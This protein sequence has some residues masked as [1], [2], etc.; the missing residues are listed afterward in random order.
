M[1]L[2]WGCEFWS[3]WSAITNGDFRYQNSLRFGTTTIRKSLT[4]SHL[5]HGTNP[6]PREFWTPL[7]AKT[8][9]TPFAD[10]VRN[11]EIRMSISAIGLLP[12]CPHDQ[13]PHGPRSPKLYS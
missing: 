1:L 4:G 9:K 5:Q 8:T 2:L 7:R 6:K 3:F 11:N 10:S 12:A 13:W